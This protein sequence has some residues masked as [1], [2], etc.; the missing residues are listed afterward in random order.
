MYDYVIVGGGSAGCVLAA[1]LSKDP[2]LSVCLVEAG[3]SDADPYIQVPA[4]GAKLFRSTHDWDYDTHPE[5]HCDNRRIYLPRGRV[6]GG[7]SSLNGMVYIRGHRDDYDSWH[8]PGWAYDDL[9][10]HFIRSEDNERGASTFHGSDGP[11]AVSDSRSRNPMA[12]AFVDAALAAGYEP[13]DDFNGASL[14]GFGR[15]QVTQREGMRCN[16]AAFLHP[17]LDRPNLTVKTHTQVHRISM[18]GD[19]ATGVEARQFGEDIH[20]G[21]E[22]EVILAAGAYNSPQL[23]MLSGIGPADDLRTLGL[24]VQVNQPLVGR[25]LQDHPQ[26]W[27]VWGHDEPVSMI[28]AGT[29]QSAEEYAA[30]RTGLLTS[31]GPEAGGFIR[32]DSRLSIPDLHLSCLPV[33]YLDGGL[34]APTGHAVSLGGFVLRPRSRG[35]VSLASDNPSAKPRVQHNYYQDEHDL[36]VAVQGVREVLNIAGQAALEPY[37]ARPVSIP[38]SD[39]SADIRTFLRENTQT[40][41]HAAGTCAMGKVTD[42]HLRV[43]GVEGLRVVDASVMPTL[44][45]GNTNAPTIGIAER[46]ADLIINALPKTE[47]AALAG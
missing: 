3:G 13:N 24:P 21:A 11:L 38:A 4:A 28:A 2:D 1:R 5:P 44:V 9:L 27:L 43:F 40:S 46:A 45:G 37:I 25:N 19:R 39:K 16:S 23:L 17:V 18:D 29:A 15:Y 6:L 22:R 7:S 26:F 36:D 20:I 34:G 14:E 30:H 8:Q 12:T 31:N 41:Y 47:P 42:S 35:Y 33:M 10:P 32:S